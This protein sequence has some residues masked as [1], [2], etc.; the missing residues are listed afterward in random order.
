MELVQT[1]MSFV[2]LAGDYA[3][4]VKKPV[5]L[6]YLDYTSLAKRR[7]Y[8]E[9]EV[10]LNSRLCPEFYLG[11]IPITRSGSVISL[12]SQ[13]EAI[14]YA[15]K[16]LRLPQDRL[17]NFLLERDR[18]SAAMVQQL[19]HKLADFHARAETN[20]YISSF[21]KIEAVRL[22]AG[23]NFAQAEKYIGIAV[24]PVQYQRI[25]DYTLGILK[26]K[27]GLFEQRV[28]DGRIRDGHGDL[29]AQHIC[30]C[31]GICIF[32]CIEFNDRFRYGDVAAE[33]A[34]MAMDLDHYGRADLSR[35]F[36]DAYVTRG[37]DTQIGEL[38][39]FY[40][41]YRAYVRGKV[42]CF[43]FDDPYISAREK[44]QALE[45]ARS[46]FDLA[47]S[48]ARSRP[49]LF[50]TVGLVG[51][52]K[53]TLARALAGRLGLT[54]ISSDILRKR[55]AS[56][57]LTE[58]RFEEMESGIYSPDFSRQ[59]YGALFEEAEKI[60]QRGDPVIL[61]ASFIRAGGPPQSPTAGGRCR[62]GLRG[63]GMQAQ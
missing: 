8:C 4:K 19:S 13:G 59:T 46:Y 39:K 53:T 30:F 56:V 35:H 12:D 18:V 58:H 52:G 36:V 42:E 28:S 32:D 33:V 47:G 55:L 38:L 15:V 63:P 27:A 43:N 40:K 11:V 34:F 62:S 61:D 10:R 6:G 48:Y 57:P 2:F 22:N 16:M 20:S 23:E 25:K 17:M 14:E 21:G 60:L 29:Y 1:Q 24:T 54:V 41:C 5:N 9:Q 49:L 45:A 7:F 37:G 51:S 31:D 44:D 26:E 50:I 3:Y